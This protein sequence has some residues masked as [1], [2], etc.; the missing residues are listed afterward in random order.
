MTTA[1]ATAA[2]TTTMT[3]TTT[4]AMVTTAKDNKDKGGRGAEA[5]TTINKKWCVEES[6][7]EIKMFFWRGSYDFFV[8]G[9]L[10]TKKKVVCTIL[11][12]V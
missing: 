7:R 11:P 4:M 3:T 1:T 6:T 8:C 10:L 9:V 5:Q 12:C 2:A